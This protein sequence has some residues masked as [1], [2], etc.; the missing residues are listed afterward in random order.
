[1]SRSTEARPAAEP[2]G[3][4]SHDGVAVITIRR[5]ERLNA[6]DPAAVCGLAAAW[7]RLEESDD[8]CAVL[9]GEGERAF[10]VG[11]DVTDVPPDFP[12]AVPGLVAPLSKPVVAAVQGY[13]VG[14]GYILVQHCDLA[15]CSDSTRFRYPE[16]A[17]GFSG[18]LASAAAARMPLKAA[19]ELMLLG[20]WMDAEQALRTS[21][22]N[23]VVPVFDVMPTA[24]DWARTIAGHAPMVVTALRDLALRTI[25]RSPVEDAAHTRFQLAAMD[26]SR[27]KQEGLAA[28]R[29]KRPP[30]FLG[31]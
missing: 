11:A 22:V 27:D 6:L 5:P 25:T 24:T 29:E 16:A 17:L 26:D 15:V 14:G 20:G 10:C 18:G 9:T 28:Q 1:M 23:R 12:R 3:Y 31:R 19:M 30:R 21:I 4:E 8:R 13:A 2:V 7:A